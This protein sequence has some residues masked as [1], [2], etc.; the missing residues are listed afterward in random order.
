V[1]EGMSLF[2]TLA[3]AWLNGFL[4]GVILA[5]GKRYRSMFIAWVE[6]HI[7]RFL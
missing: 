3:A 6:N 1:E 4:V 5:L 2:V 7:R